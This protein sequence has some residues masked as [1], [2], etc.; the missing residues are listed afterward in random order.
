MGST[1]IICLRNKDNVPVAML[2]DQR[3]ASCYS[4]VKEYLWNSARGRYDYV[5]LN[6]P[7]GVQ[8]PS[9]QEH[10][11]KYL[12]RQGDPLHIDLQDECYR[13]YNSEAIYSV[14][15]EQQLI[16]VY[17]KHSYDYFDEGYN[18]IRP[19]PLA[20]NEFSVGGYIHPRVV[21]TYFKDTLRMI[22]ELKDFIGPND[23]PFSIDVL[24]G[25]HHI[26]QTLLLL[27]LVRRLDESP[28]GYTV[29]NIII[30]ARALA[31]IAP[32][33]AYYY[34]LTLEAAWLGGI[35]EPLYG[36]IG[37]NTLPID[38]SNPWHK[39]IN[40][41]RDM[42]HRSDKHE[43]H[44]LNSFI[45]TDTLYHP[46][47]PRYNGELDHMLHLSNITSIIRNGVLPETIGDRDYFN[48]MES[49]TLLV[50]DS[51]LKM[52]AKITTHRGLKRPPKGYGPGDKMVIFHFGLF[53]EQV[54]QAYHEIR[55]HGCIKSVEILDQLNNVIQTL[56]RKPIDYFIREG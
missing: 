32:G 27:W 17:F 4:K 42:T 19:L 12:D 35:R 22:P 53:P 36:N 34:L 46:L 52:I 56:A 10:Y 5:S 50:T 16:R 1:Y 43:S 26:R 18:T 7:W 33:L 29:P 6:K 11:Q 30:T 2:D 28:S 47:D 38:E 39:N 8:H 37:Y 3:D 44:C 48:R 41:L 55:D 45:A 23:D 9:F 54:E 24:L 25:R 13:H 14:P 21:G 40:L 20:D 49:G 15:A 31:S 51:I